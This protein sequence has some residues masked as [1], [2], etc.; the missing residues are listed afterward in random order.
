MFSEYKSKQPKKCRN[1]I[2][3]HWDGLKQFCSK[4]TCIKEI[5]PLYT[6]A[7]PIEVILAGD[8]RDHGDVSNES[9]ENMLGSIK[10]IR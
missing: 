2:W 9:G 5:P 3:G 4:S 7:H 1:C 6:V 10:G 8:R